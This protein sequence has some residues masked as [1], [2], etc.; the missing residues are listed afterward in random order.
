M[1]TPKS[2]WRAFLWDQHHLAVLNS[3]ELWHNKDIVISIPDKG[4]GVVVMDRKEYVKKITEISFHDNK[5]QRVGK[6]ETRDN[7]LLTERAL[8][9]FLMRQQ[10][11]GTISKGVYERIRPI[12]ASRPSMYGILKLHKTG[13]P[14]R[15]AHHLYIAGRHC[16]LEAVNPERI[17]IHPTSWTG[18][19]NKC[20]TVE[21]TLTHQTN[22]VAVR[23]WIFGVNFSMPWEAHFHH[24]LH[25]RLSQPRMLSPVKA[26]DILPATE[27]S[28]LVYECK[29]CCGRTYVGRTIQRLSETI[30]QHVPDQLF[31]E[32]SDLKRSRSNSAQTLEG[33]PL[34]YFEE[35]TQQI[36]DSCLSQ[37][38]V[39]SECAG[40][41]IHFTLFS[42]SLS[43][44]VV[45]KILFKCCYCF[46]MFST[47]VPA[48]H[49]SCHLL[50]QTFFC[51]KRLIWLV[52]YWSLCLLSS[53]AIVA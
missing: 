42:L 28:L 14:L 25:V 2:A 49:G 30:K 3:K 48:D 8:Q 33:K 21:I 16:H 44:F 45:L 34:L 12:R 26:K 35:H 36:H 15:S 31:Q 41:L 50:L 46:E 40:G 24:F 39:A 6:M 43:L 47:L 4:N 19:F 11:A 17:V 18:Q 53:L 51:C 7:T 22:K 13:K 20:W 10:K 32:T 29:C 38:W 23:V 52:I 5:F 27:K 1:L 37:V 9:A